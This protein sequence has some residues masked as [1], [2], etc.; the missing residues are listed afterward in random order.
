MTNA[1]EAGDV[2]KGRKLFNSC[3]ACH[4]FWDKKKL[5]GPNLKGMF[6]RPIGSLSGFSYSKG[7]AAIGA[8]GTKWSDVGLDRFLAKP[9]EFISDTKMNYAGMTSA[10]DREDLIAYLRHQANR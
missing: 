10:S 3:K 8:D 7:M 1:A 2:R 4:S 6:D 9:K 5:F